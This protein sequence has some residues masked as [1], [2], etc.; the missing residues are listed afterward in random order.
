MPKKTKNKNTEKTES[1]VSD[2]AQQADQAIE[3]HQESITD[4]VPA[5]TT[6]S[7]TQDDEV[8]KSSQK[9]EKLVV[10]QSKEL[11]K[12]SIDLSNQSSENLSKDSFEK[13]LG[14]EVKKHNQDLCAQ[15]VNVGRDIEY[16]LI[17]SKSSIYCYARFVKAQRP[18]ES[19]PEWELEFSANIPPMLHRDI[20]A[21]A[22]ACGTHDSRRV[23]FNPSGMI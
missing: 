21:I 4:T 2:L 22:H 17:K 13:K 16:I 15:L 20:L 3:T 7:V 5:E 1:V 19:S 14:D 8:E 23:F 10:D 18:S 12:N 9:F 6:E 11:D